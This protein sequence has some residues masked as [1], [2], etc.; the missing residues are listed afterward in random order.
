MKYAPTPSIESYNIRLS[1][2]VKLA[3][4]FSVLNDVL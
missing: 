3:L 4:R 1:T 2:Q